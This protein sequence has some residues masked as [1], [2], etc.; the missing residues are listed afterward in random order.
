M[1]RVYVTSCLLTVAACDVSIPDGLGLCSIIQPV[2]LGRSCLDSEDSTGSGG[3][4]GDV[5]VEGPPCEGDPWVC[6]AGT[7]CE[8][9]GTGGP[10]TCKPSGSGKKGDSCMQGPKPECGDG[11]FCGVF[12]SGYAYCVPTCRQGD[13]EHACEAGE[14]CTGA[15]PG[16]CMP[17]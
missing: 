11:L 12:E 17:Y 5:G 13:A 3:S 4:G 2:L 9:D 6:T 7:T 15:S 16:L 8:S 14:E 1:Y 10:L